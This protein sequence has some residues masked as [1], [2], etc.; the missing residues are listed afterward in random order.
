MDQ[1]L[2]EFFDS[3][4]NSY[5]V[6]ITKRLTIEALG[7]L[8][9]Y[10]FTGGNYAERAQEYA[11]DAI[12]EAFAR[13]MDNAPTRF[14]LHRGD[15]SAPLENRFW[16]YLLFNCLRPL[17]TRDAE[18]WKSRSRWPIVP[19]ED[20]I[21]IPD[22]VSTESE[23]AAAQI[24]DELLDGASGELKKLILAARQQFENDPNQKNINWTEIQKTLGIT[25]YACDILRKELDALRL[26]F[27]AN[28]GSQ[29]IAAP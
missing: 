4:Q 10:G 8:S 5:W 11:L 19:L 20:A 12:E 25:R 24:L 1:E 22:S 13:C 3:H 28:Q 23:N 27:L 14:D 9:K 18:K 15:Q 26:Q 7:L 29:T 21:D 17:I 6:E 2:R 16:S